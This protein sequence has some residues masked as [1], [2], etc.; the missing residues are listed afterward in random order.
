MFIDFS[1]EILLNIEEIDRQHEKWIELYN[2]MYRV[3]I[4]DQIQ[5]RQSEIELLVKEMYE[6]TKEHFKFEEEI[7]RKISYPNAVTHRSSH[8]QMDDTIYKYYRSVL[9]NN[10]VSGRSVF[11]LLKVWITDHILKDD[12]EYADYIVENNIDLNEIVR[13]IKAE[14]SSK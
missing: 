1:K 11:A 5:D 6:Y 7:L 9:D 4:D 12:R 3:M 8:K 10:F 14:Q 2:E 13:S